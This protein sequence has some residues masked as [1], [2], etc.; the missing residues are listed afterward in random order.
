MKT[1]KIILIILNILFINTFCYSQWEQQKNGLPDNWGLGHAIDACDSNNAVIC[2]SSLD[3]PEPDNIYKTTNGGENWINITPSNIN[4]SESPEDICMIDANNI[5]IVTVADSAK[6]LHTNNGGSSWSEQY[7]DSTKTKYFNYIEMFDLNNGVAMGDAPNNSG[8]ALFLQTNDGGKNWIEMENNF[9]I[10]ASADSWRRL[11]FVSPEIGYIH[12]NWGVTLPEKRGIIKTT[13][14]GNNWDVVAQIF[15][16]DILKFYDENIGIVK[17]GL[18]E[19]GNFYSVISRTTDGGINWQSFDIDSI[20]WGNDFEFIP[21]DP[22][23]VWLCDGYG[24]HLF[25]SNDTGSTWERINF[26]EIELIGRDI[27]F[28]DENHGWILSDYGILLH[29]NNNG[30]I[31]TNIKEIENFK[32]QN[33]FELRQNYPN[34]F[35]PNTKISYSIPNVASSFSSSQI[36]QIKVYDILGKEIS[37]LVNEQ[38]SAGNYE[39]NF[40]AEN[41]PSGIYFY[42]LQV[43]EFS[44]IKKMILLK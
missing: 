37:T 11:D 41:L 10:N 6:I 14:G 25:F 29:T 44:E 1:Q 27:V 8:K 2:F 13:D 24:G 43:G 4:W 28:V 22:S 5:W 20:G 40:N 26:S 30:G 33:K 32:I 34:P 36:V 38:K 3:W 21:N 31:I 12:D 18:N 16:V 35:N 9:Q 39:V 42:K 7:N 19:N 15:G 23:R 17:R